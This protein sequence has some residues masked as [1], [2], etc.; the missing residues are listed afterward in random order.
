LKIKSIGFIGG[1]RLA[2]ANLGYDMAF[3]FSKLGIQAKLIIKE[4]HL[5][6]W[7]KLHPNMDPYADKILSIIP[8]KSST[9]RILRNIREALNARKFD[10]IFS[11]GLGGLWYLPYIG[12]PYV[13]YATGADLTELA[14][15]KGYSG[16]Q[17][18]QAKKVFR[19]AKLVF[20]SV[21]KGHQK[22]IKKL[23]LKN[24]IPWR[25]FIDTNFWS[26]P[27]NYQRNDKKILK[28]FHPTSL[29]WI[30]KFEGQRLKSNDILFRG[31]KK[32]IDNGG[33]GK[34]FFRKR[35]QNVRETEDLIQELDLTKHIEILPDS[36]V[37]EEQKKV[38]S[39]M[40]IVADQFGVGNFGLIALEAMSLGKPVITFFPEDAAKLS[41]PPPDEAPPILNASTS[42]EI[43][44]KLIE[45]QDKKILYKYSIESR[46]WIEK[47][48]QESILA[49]WYLKILEEFI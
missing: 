27:I 14:D 48:H 29:D 12:K 28:I 19:K 6:E 9:N 16:F 43:M 47:Y 25:Q 22:M 5:D 32:F 30:P 2:S 34:L 41:Y 42:D 46:R 15:G 3:H 26:M 36:K 44:Q 11:I 20:Y 13:S 7:K 23:N 35:G 17:V 49:K 10:I 40:D 4:S 37:R 1:F 21:E 31:F 38:M 18:N 45:L 24:I 8:E 33:Q 39:N